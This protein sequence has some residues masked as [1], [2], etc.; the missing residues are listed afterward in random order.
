MD[1]WIQHDLT[2]IQH[3]DI[4]DDGVCDRV[5]TGC[6]YQQQINYDSASNIELGLDVLIQQH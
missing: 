2:M 1:V 5:V 4:M 6:I 3:L